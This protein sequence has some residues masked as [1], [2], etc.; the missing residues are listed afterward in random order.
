MFDRPSGLRPSDAELTEAF[1][2]VAAR[3]AARLSQRETAPVA[4]AATPGAARPLAEAGFPSAGRPLAE[5]MDELADVVLAQ[6]TRTDHRRFFA[7]IPSPASP[8]SALGEALVAAHNPHAGNWS[9]S[10]G[11]AL[12][13]AALIRFL[14][15]ALGLPETAGGLFV[16][17][18]SMA[19]LAGVVAARDAKL[20]DG[21][22]ARGVAYMTAEAHVSVGRA[23]AI[24]GVA[25]DRVHI[26]PADERGAMR[27]EALEAAVDADRAAELSPFLVV[28]SAGTTGVGAIDPIAGIA[29]V[30]ERRDLWLHVD[31]AYGASVAL[32][33]SRRALLDGVERADSVAWDGHKWLF[34]TYGCGMVFVRDRSR[35]IASFRTDADYLRQAEAPEGDANFWDLGPE[36]TRPAR[37][38]KLWLTLEVLGLDAIARAIEH[39]VALA[40]TAERLIRM[41]DGWTVATPASLAIV[42]FRFAPEGLGPDSADVVNAEAARRLLAEGYAAVGVARVNRRCAL[43]L[44]VINPDTTED[45]VAETLRRLDLHARAALDAVL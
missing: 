39:G 21:S 37:A 32:C 19:N 25:R 35:L 42:T 8:V 6:A 31:G 13:E 44:C 29:D 43:R 34:Q 26:V 10:P 14:A 41:R 16:S 17:G 30:A 7:F 27:I 36:L 22:L 20:A 1:A 3:L 40:E 18:G 24:A 28:A 11:P 15:R 33:P 9:Q 45:E 2:G 4:P 5:V 12:I 23:L 38:L